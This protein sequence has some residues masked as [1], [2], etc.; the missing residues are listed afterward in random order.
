MVFNLK[1]FAE[2]M[3]RN[4]HDINRQRTK[5]NEVNLERENRSSIDCLM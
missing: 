2:K 5:E 4:E 3:K 1:N